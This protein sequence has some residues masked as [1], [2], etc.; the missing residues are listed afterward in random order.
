MK[1]APASLFFLGIVGFV[2]SAYLVAT[3][4][5]DASWGTAFCIAFLIMFI[6]GIIS[7]TP[8][9]D[10]EYKL[11]LDEDEVKEKAEIPL[12]VKKTVKTKKKKK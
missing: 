3:E 4:V 2:V 1:P 7:I 12:P 11:S 6:S 5:L 8:E 9:D 10:L